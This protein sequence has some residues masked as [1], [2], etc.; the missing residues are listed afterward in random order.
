MANPGSVRYIPGHP[1][2]RAAPT[3]IATIAIT[4]LTAST[5]SPVNALPMLHPAAS[6]PPMPMNTP[7]VKGE[8]AQLV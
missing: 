2:A 5:D 7:P 1:T 4:L 6:V 8:R 3:T